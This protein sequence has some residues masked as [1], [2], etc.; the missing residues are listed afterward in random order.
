MN[1]SITTERGQFSPFQA[2]EFKDLSSSEN[3]MK[4]V[5]GENEFSSNAYNT[6]LY[7]NNP[8]GKVEGQLVW[9]KETEDLAAQYVTVPSQLWFPNT[10]NCE[11]TILSVNTATHPSHQRRGLFV[12]SAKLTF[13][14]AQ[15]HGFS[16]VYGFPNDNSLPGFKKMGF[17]QLS[18][19]HIRAR[20]ISILN[21]AGSAFSILKQWHS[22][23]LTEMHKQLSDPFQRAMPKLPVTSALIKNF[24]HV[25]RSKEWIEWRYAKHPTRKYFFFLWNDCVAVLRP[26]EISGLKLCLLMDLIGEVTDSFVKALDKHLKSEKINLMVGV[27]SDSLSAISPRTAKALWLRVPSRLSPKSFHVIFKP[28][29][30]SGHIEKSF[31]TLGD[32]D[33]Y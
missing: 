4:I 17:T 30:H 18:A 33:I 6:W 19:L 9:H 22:P 7:R 24:L 20:P 13:E 12:K 16:A 10:N 11:K 31:F 32:I 21:L 27:F 29:K 15:Q 23:N 14:H 3:L 5:W 8:L 25:P 1:K 28:L 2:D 26:M